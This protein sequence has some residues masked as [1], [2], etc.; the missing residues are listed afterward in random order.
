MKKLVSILVICVVL[1]AIVTPRIIELI[2]SKNAVEEAIKPLT[3][4]GV[5]VVE[6]DLSTAIELIGNT[7]ANESVP[8]FPSFPAK[9][10]AIDVKVGDKVA[11][12]DLLFSLD[13]KDLD[14]QITQANF[15]IDQASSAVSMANVGVKNANVSIETANIAYDMAKSNYE[16][17]LANYNFAKDNLSKYEQLYADGIVSQVE[18]EQVKLQASPETLTL[19]DSQLKQAEKALSQA[20]LSKEQA[21]ASVNQASVGLNQ[22]KDGLSTANDAIRDLDMKSDVAGYVTTINIAKDV[23]ASNAQAAMMIEDLDTI[24]VIVNVTANIENRFHVGNKVEV[25]IS[26]S[27]KSYEGIVDTVGLTADSR[28]LLYPITVKID[29]PNLEIK[30]GMFA[31]V[32]VIDQEVTKALTVPT[33]SV[34]V[35]N[36]QDIVFVQAGDNRVEERAI[37]KGIDTG[38]FVEIKEG[39]TLEDIIITKGAGLI[40][41]TTDVKVIRGDE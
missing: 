28:T 4:E 24:K 12:G 14:G 39:I 31:T 1:G 33:E 21:N 32:K 19:L 25:I 2:N 30:P 20:Q 41:A 3:I 15:G 17:N 7:F 9:I 23:M 38:Y 22:A 34:L 11:I 36:G 37:V 40:D 10:M 29:N 6:Q 27:G 35:R 16:M 18:Y 26:S 5:K 13:P 8:V